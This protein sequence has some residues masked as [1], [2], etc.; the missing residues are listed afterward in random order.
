MGK[1]SKL[2]LSSL[3]QDSLVDVKVIGKD[4]Y[5]RVL[6]RIF[7]NGKDINLLLVTNGMAWAYEEYVNDQE[8]INAQVKAKK[9]SQGLWSL[10]NPIEPW[11]WRNDPVVKNCCRICV[12]GK[13][14]GDSCINS[15]YSCKKP[16]G[17]ACNS[18]I[19]D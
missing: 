11:K 8:I 7:F 10:N 15:S 16:V 12:K 1:A 19:Q 9:G 14:C 4:K 3:L 2:L 18:S 13:A 5:G 6:G 17:C